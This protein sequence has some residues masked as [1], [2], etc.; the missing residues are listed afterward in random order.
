DGDRV[1]LCSGIVVHKVQLN[2]LLGDVAQLIYDFGSTLKSHKIDSILAATLSSILLLD[3]N[4]SGTDF[5]L[6]FLKK[7]PI[8]LDYVYHRTP[9]SSTVTELY[10]KIVDSLKD[11]LKQQHEDS[12]VYLQLLDRLNEARRIAHLLRK[13]LSLYRHTS[14]LTNSMNTLLDLVLECKP[15]SND[16]PSNEENSSLPFVQYDI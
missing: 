8:R 16:L 2:Y 10:Q 13:R 12:S 3:S 15:I 11:Y 6:E 14:G 4:N 1:V 5:Q 9:L 7:D